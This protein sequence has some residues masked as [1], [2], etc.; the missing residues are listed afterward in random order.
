[1]ISQANV[2]P[3]TPMGA[4]LV[5]GGATFRAWAPAAVAVYVNGEFGGVSSWTTDTSDDLLM[6]RDADGYWSGFVPGAKN[7]DPYK[8]Y[9][10]GTGSSG[11][12]RDPYARELTVDPAYPHCNCLIRPSGTTF[13][14]A[15][16]AFVTPDFSNMILYQLHV[17]T[18]NGPPGQ[19]GTFLD[20][21]TKVPYLAALGIN[22]LQPMPIDECKTE[23]TEGY[24]GTDF[25]SPDTPYGVPAANLAPYLATLNPF[26]TA[27]GAAPLTLDAITAAPD[28][29]RALVDLCHLYGI[30]VAFDVVYNHAGGFEGDDESLLFWDRR[31][32]GN[33]NDSQYF[34]DAGYVGG[35]SFALW[36]QDVRQFLINSARYYAEEFHIDGIRYDQI[37][38]LIGMNGSSGIAFVDAIAGTLRDLH[39]RFVQNAEYWGVN[40]IV[41]AP[42][43]AGGYGF[44]VTQHDALRIALR[45]AISQ[46]SYGASAPVSMTAIAQALYPP[47]FPHGWQAVPCAENH[48]IVRVGAQL[49]IPAL[50]DG[51]D[52]WSW[53]AR[54]R[55]RVA[56][57]VVLTA[58][59]IPQLFMGQEFFEDKPWDE[60]VDAPNRINWAGLD[61]GEKPMSDFLR[62]TQ[63]A[64]GLRWRQPAL[65][66]DVVNAFHI[67][68]ENR[69]LAFQRLDFAGARDV[70]VVA[71][72]NDTT[73]DG[74]RIGFPAG[75][76]WLE[77]FNSDVYDGW[78]NPNV[79]GN[80]G[81]IVADGSQ[82]LHGFA[83]SASIVIPANGVV[84]FARDAG[85]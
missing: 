36:N 37:S 85:E 45:A 70:I 29:L 61:A 63:D 15:D 2:S 23:P 64:I 71:S 17:G 47:W 42:V 83:A 4:N 10:V 33:N 84:V 22:V 82:P 72:L 75:G 26:R 54:S 77:V 27:K 62:F 43:S 60:D 16:Q 44:D 69:V 80:G 1:M 41:V 11:Y 57:A 6:Q 67:N 21:A 25:F 55:S 74:Y 8:F 68:D 9:V 76:T 78:V 79:A 14:W 73:Y 59:G 56:M 18:Y 46:A 52:H 39:P 24:N 50:A 12:K 13:P 48:D 7:G 38:D 58:P 3:D 49:R 81:S 19:T 66:A 34:T 53:Y 30:A 35:L 32:A 51:S 40:P 65:R 5:A 20:V 31:P 28:Q